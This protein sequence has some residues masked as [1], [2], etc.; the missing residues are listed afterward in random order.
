[1]SIGFKPYARKKIGRRPRFGGMCQ[2]RL[3][4][5]FNTLFQ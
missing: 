3:V 2:L 1:M 5:K 4:V